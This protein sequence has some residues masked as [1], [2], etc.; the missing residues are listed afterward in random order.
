MR[1]SIAPVALALLAGC[2]QLPPTHYYVLEIDR[3]PAAAAASG[4]V[5]IGVRPFA[6]DAPYDQE[7]IVY[8]IGER[9]PEVGFYSY[10]LWAAPLSSMLPAAVAGALSGTAG[11]L[12]I[13][14]VASAR[15][16]DAYLLGRVLAVEEIDVGERQLVRA[17]IELRLVD[18]GGA[19]LWSRT[20]E[21]NGEARAG[22][23]SAIVEELVRALGAALDEARGGLAGALLRKC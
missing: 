14:P 11:V 13:E 21:A 10:H 3:P 6:V 5:S 1:R 23:V 15:K 9:S 17:A 2:S 7:R 4:A 8:R 22:E 19:E 18:P 16:Y 12:E 20:I